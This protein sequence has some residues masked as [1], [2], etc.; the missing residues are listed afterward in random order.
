MAEILDPLLVLDRPEILQIVFY[1][2]RS[3]AAEEDD[4]K[5]LFFEVDEGVKIGCRLYEAGR[6]FPTIL[7][8]HGNGE[9]V[10][11]YDDTARCYIEKNINLL[12]ADYRG[13]GFSNGQPTIANILK[14]G[15][16]IF[17]QAKTWLTK[18]GYAEVIFVMGRSLGSI[19]A[20]EV[21]K[22]HQDDL[23]GLIIE[24]GSATN[25][26]NLLYIWGFFPL[27]HPIWREG[28]GFFSKEKIRQIK[29][30]IL[31]IHAE[32]DSL[33]PLREAELLYKNAGTESKKLVVIPGADHNDLMV[34]GEELYFRTISD[35]VQSS[36][37]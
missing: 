13:Y 17:P 6:N 8:F 9:I 10:T 11:D 33:I 4:E 34:V 24:S 3:Y 12:V 35:F 2:R 1:P 32:R 25:F 29:I 26:R 20:I 27:D 28:S 19:C 22:L 21:A 7:F 15:N 36:T 23:T 5:N 37:T 30:P 14:D 16:V 18:H 31:I